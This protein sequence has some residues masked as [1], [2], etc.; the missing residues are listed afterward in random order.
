MLCL[1]S[2]TLLIVSPVSTKVVRVGNS[3]RVIVNNTVGFEDHYVLSS[4]LCLHM[5]HLSMFVYVRVS[6]VSNV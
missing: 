6:I 1:V 3:F 4:V 2:V 5:H